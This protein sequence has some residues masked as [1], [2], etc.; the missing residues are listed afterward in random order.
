MVEGE[1]LL[2][3]PVGI[4]ALEHFVV[5][6]LVAGSYT[7]KLLDARYALHTHVAG[8]LYGIRA[9]RSDHLFT[10]PNELASDEGDT[11]RASS[12]EEPGELFVL[13]GSEGMIG[14]DSDE[15]R[16]PVFEKYNHANR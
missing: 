4:E 5:M 6:R 15:T 3:E 12:V 9:P 13:F 16:G 2:A 1:N 7:K 10:G 14:G 8:N 11:C